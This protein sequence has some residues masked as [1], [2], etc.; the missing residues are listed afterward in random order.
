[1]LAPFP[2]HCFFSRKSMAQR[3]RAHVFIFLR[4]NI[5]NYNMCTS[6]RRLCLLSEL[7]FGGAC[8]RKSKYS[9]QVKCLAGHQDNS[10]EI[11]TVLPDSG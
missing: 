9:G 3:A 7:V 10:A 2:F 6:L 4:K 5:Y 11:G 1:M 8:D